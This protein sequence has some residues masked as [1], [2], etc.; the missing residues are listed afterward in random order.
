[1]IWLAEAVMVIGIVIIC[2]I[3]V[4]MAVEAFSRE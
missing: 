4:A 3:L 2:G 1:M